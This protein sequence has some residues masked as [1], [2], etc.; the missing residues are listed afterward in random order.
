MF[1]EVPVVVALLVLT[2][3][4][5]LITR[6]QDQNSPPGPFSYPLLGNFPQLGPVLHLSLTD[7]GKDFNGLYRLHLMGKKINVINRGKTAKD[8]LV[9]EGKNV[10]DR[11]SA[12]V[13]DLMTRNGCSLIFGKLGP[14]W[15][16]Q[17]KMVHSALRFYSGGSADVENLI[18]KEANELN[19]ILRSTKGT[20][21]DPKLPLTLCVMNVICSLV[22][23]KRYELDDKEFHQIVTNTEALAKLASPENPLI[24]LPWLRHFP[25]K[26]VKRMNEII[27]ERDRIVKEKID[28]HR[29]SYRSGVTRDLTDTIL[30]CMEDENNNGLLTDDHLHMAVSDVFLAGFETTTTALRWILLYLILYPEVQAK[31]HQ[32]LDEVVGSDQAP[33]LEHKERLPYLQATINEVM[34]ISPVFPIIRRKAIGD[35]K[36][37]GYDINKGSFVYVN[38]WAI[39]HDPEEWD[40]PYEFRPERFLKDPE[41]SQNMFPFGAGTR[42]CIGK[43]LAK[44]ELF[45]IVSR[46]LHEFELTLPPGSMR[47]D[48]TGLTS[49]VYW[50]KPF[51]VCAV[52]R[53]QNFNNVE[54]C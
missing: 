17:R 22:Y 10:G 15:K 18:I 28:D 50:P 23:G 8:V 53:F 40:S 33:W 21:I 16:S 31:I 3:L 52:K 38:L 35:F 1:V 45:L 6:K 24:L 34:R 4:Y 7:L 12:Y 29:R 2:T 51:Q 30:K 47:P 36:I 25:I 41:K 20:A 13:I 54:L 26:T 5:F 39:H 9:N 37:D 11:T 14:T 19:E 32:E 43:S 42:V 27:K 44:S 48:P 49:T 46:L